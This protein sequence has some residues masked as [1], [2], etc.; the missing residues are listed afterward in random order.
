MNI[1]GRILYLHTLPALR[2]PTGNNAPLSG[3]RAIDVGSKIWVR[4]ITRKASQALL[5]IL[6]TACWGSALAQTT[7]A[8]QYQVS[9]LDDLGG[10]N[11]RGNSINNRGWVAGYSLL[12]G[13]QNRHSAACR[14]WSPSRRE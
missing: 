3:L 9:Y 2:I 14:F 7:A 5:V 10:T 11:S 13:D 12:E 4:S 6:L 8:Q 1:Q